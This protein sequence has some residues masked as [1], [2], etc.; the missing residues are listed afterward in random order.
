MD[1][2][3][4]K[5]LEMT[6]YGSIAIA[7]VLVLRVIFRKVPK[8]VTCLFWIVAGIRL[9]C[10]FNFKTRFGIMNLFEKKK[11]VI[12]TTQP[13]REV[14]IPVI[15]S[16][17]HHEVKDTVPVK[18]HEVVSN[19]SKTN[20]S[21]PVL[22][23]SI[24]I[25]GTLIFL[26]TMMI[27]YIKLQ[28]NIGKGNK[29]G[30]VI[31][32]DKVDTPF[33]TG[34]F[35]PKIVLP[36]FVDPRERDYLIMHEKIHMKNMDNLTRALGLV[37]VCIHWF[38]PLVWIAFSM[39]CNDLEMRVDEEV[40]DR[41][42]NDIKKDYCLSIVNHAMKRQR[43]KVFGA[44]F[45]K[46]TLSGLE[47]KMRINNLIKYK[48]ISSLATALIVVVSMGV[49]AVLSSCSNE[50]TDKVIDSVVSSEETTA[51]KTESPESE[52]ATSTTE[53]EWTPP[54]EE[55]GEIQK[56]CI[57]YSGDSNSL[58]VNGSDQDEAYGNFILVDYIEPE[59]EGTFPEIQI[60]SEPN[61]F[62][63]T[64]VYDLAQEYSDQ[65]YILIDADY[66]SHEDIPNFDVGFN[67]ISDGDGPYVV[68]LHLSEEGI[69]YIDIT[70]IGMDEWIEGYTCNTIST[71]YNE[72]YEETGDW[73]VEAEYI[74]E[75][76]NDK[77]YLVGEYDGSTGILIITITR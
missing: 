52:E 50:K 40:I 44:S 10:P 77:A 8:K 37:I 72:N 45:A 1:E 24:W 42:G 70:S 6:L 64:D 17:V 69:S 61:Y 59:Q 73:K 29:V 27:R 48:K 11:E 21:L 54:W 28:K 67:A 68:V 13:I 2:L 33:V 55:G 53:G 41:I 25:L 51:A 9:L 66:Y 12:P 34:F 3:L 62:E 35:R 43:Y 22:L 26:G 75:N 47:V 19:A 15:T 65:G 49:T 60:I 31:E 23:I 20:I 71:S 16:V 4:R 57:Y 76:E 32:S 56:V 5:L 74:G 39:L 46:K 30:D 58:T 36:T 63:N 18:A 7:V 38:N 14:K